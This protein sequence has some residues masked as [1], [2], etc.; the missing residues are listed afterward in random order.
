MVKKIIDGDT[1]EV[2][3]NPS[4]V[5]QLIYDWVVKSYG[6]SEIEN[7]SWNIP[8]LAK[9]INENLSNDNYQPLCLVKYNLEEES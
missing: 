5:E 8:E 3:E 6:W 9:W 4:K 2:P 7:P 1:Y